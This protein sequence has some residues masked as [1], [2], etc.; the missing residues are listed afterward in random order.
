MKNTKNNTYRNFWWLCLALFGRTREKVNKEFE[1]RVE[2][3]RRWKPERRVCCCL[4]GCLF[5][6]FVWER[7]IIEKALRVSYLYMLCE[8]V[9]PPRVSYCWANNMGFLTLI[10]LFSDFCGPHFKKKHN[11]PRW[12]KKI[13]RKILTIK[14]WYTKN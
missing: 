12:N 5:V 4:L 14:L 10:S 2:K 9:G 11:L 6:C 3:R 8:V 13:K 7:I 1:E